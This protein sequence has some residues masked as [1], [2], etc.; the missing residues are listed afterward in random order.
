VQQA[1]NKVGAVEAARGCID[2]LGGNRYLL[3]V[4]W[5]GVQATAPAS[6]ACGQNAYADEALRRGVSLVLQVA[7]LTAP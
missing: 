2:S 4:V 1:G 3:A 5:Q 6:V 7:D